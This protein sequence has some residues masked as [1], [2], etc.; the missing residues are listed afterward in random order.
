[1]TTLRDLLKN[2]SLQAGDQLVWNRRTSGS[3]HRAEVNS[4]GQIV[5]E[6][7]TKHKTPSGAAKHLNGGKSVDGWIV[8]KLVR[9][10][11]ALGNLRK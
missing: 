6:D 1:M 5:L 10:S 2:G 7:G 9:T 3:T 11:S 8:W 4:M